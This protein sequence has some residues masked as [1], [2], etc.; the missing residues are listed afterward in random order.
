MFDSLPQIVWNLRWLMY[1]RDPDPAKWPSLLSEGTRHFIRSNRARQI[2]ERGDLGLT[3]SELGAIL[4]CYGLDREELMSVPMYGAKESIRRENLKYLIRALPKGAAKQAAGKIGITASQLSRWKNN[5]ERPHP[6]N[7]RK[8][9]KFHGMDP[10][11]D[12][13][14]ESLFLSMDPL[15]GFAKKAWVLNRVKEMSPSEIAEIYT[16]LKRILG[17]Y[18]NH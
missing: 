6:T 4:E 16:G 14:S 12:I 17:S 1:R 10:D 3:E 7:F 8:L 18:E 11:L 15:S 9:L 13:D 5:V 2:L